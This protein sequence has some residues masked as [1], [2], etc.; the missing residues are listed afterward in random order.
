[1][2][3]EER[4]ADDHQREGEEPAEAVADDRVRAV[5]AD[6][7]RRPPLLDSAR[8]VEIDLVGRHRRAEQTDHEVRVEQ[9]VVVG[10]VRDE[11]VADLAPVGP[12]FT[13]ATAKTSMQ[14]PPYP[15]IRSIH[16]NDVTQIT[17][18]ETTTVASTISQR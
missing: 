14:S 9:L 8:G 13:A 1:M 2:G 7:L 15:K 10:K 16:S 3:E 11:A 12:S 6:V 5:Q 18:P 4:A 17:T